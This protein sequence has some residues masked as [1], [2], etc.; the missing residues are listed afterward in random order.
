LYVILREYP[1]EESLIFPRVIPHVA[2]A[3]MRDPVSIIHPMKKIIFL[4]TFFIILIASLATS[5]FIF[6]NQKTSEQAEAAALKSGL[7]GWWTMDSN[8]LTAT[9]IFDK[10]G[11]NNSGTPAGFYT[12]QAPTSTQGKIGQAINFD[13]GNG[14]ISVLDSNNLDFNN[15]I[16]VSAWIKP[17]IVGQNREIMR[18][19]NASEKRLLFSMQTSNVLSLGTYYGSYSELDYSGFNSSYLNKWTHV[20]ATHDSSGNRR[21]YVNGTQVANDTVVGTLDISGAA[22]LWIGA[23]RGL[24]EFLN[25]SLDDVRLYNRALSAQEISQLYNSAKTTYT[26]SAPKEKQSSGKLVGWWTMDSNDINGTAIYDKSGLNYVATSIGTSNTAGQIKEARSFNGSTDYID[27]N[28]AGDLTGDITVSAWIKPTA[29]AGEYNTVMA[30]SAETFSGI[31]WELSVHNT[32]QLFFTGSNG[33]TTFRASKSGIVLNKWQHVVGTYNGTTKVFNVYINAAI[34]TS[35]TLT[36]TKSTTAG[37]AKIG[38]ENHATAYYPFTGTIDDVRIYNYVLSAQ[39]VANLYN[40]AKTTYVTS[41]PKSGLVGWW[42]MDDNDSTASL[43]YDKSGLN[44]NATV[45][46]FYANR[47][48]TSTPG[49][50][51]QSIYFDKFNGKITR[52]GLNGLATSNNS[53]ETI[54]AWVKVAGSGGTWQVAMQIGSSVNSLD[55]ACES[56]DNQQCGCDFYN[57]IV[58]SVNIGYDK[59]THITCAYNGTGVTQYINGEYSSYEPGAILVNNNVSIGY[60]GRNANQSFLGSLDD[61]RIYNRALSATEVLQLYNSAKTNYK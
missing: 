55:I 46:G 32:N 39:D 52:T 51:S 44:N 49:K 5:F 31:Q 28:G 18:K 60:D 36:G 22:N 34:G 61:V 37:T 33:S 58:N 57:G 56:A 17:G 12:G 11:F 42:T 35:A 16:T 10:S 3:E 40:S 45:T 21:M 20:A 50:L 27:L 30:K 29:Y 24:Y 1:T 13:G 4:T 7:V 19:E 14:A 9:K 6:K 41:A 23:D 2:T 59:W 47:A 48:P 53:R 43:V 8:D 26:N 25:A 38:R 15:E 54:S